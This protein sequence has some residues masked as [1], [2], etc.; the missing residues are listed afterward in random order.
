MARACRVNSE[1]HK[2]FFIAAA[3]WCRSRS[4][5]TIRPCGMFKYIHAA[6]IK[7]EYPALAAF[8]AFSFT[9]KDGVYA[10]RGQDVRSG[11]FRYPQ[12]RVFLES[13]R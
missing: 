6:A 5:A 3:W 4:G 12:A 2:D 13:R 1:N 8:A 7:R 9:S 10:A 11:D